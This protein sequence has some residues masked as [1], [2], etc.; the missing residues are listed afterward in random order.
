M[1]LDL[2]HQLGLYVGT[3]EMELNAFWRRICREGYTAFDCGSNQGYH[4]LAIAKRTHAQVVA[5]EPNDVALGLLRRNLRWNE[6][7]APYVSI[8]E[9]LVGAPGDPRSGA[10]TLDEVAFGPTAG[11]VPDLVKIDIE[12]AEAEALA[13]ARQLLNSRRP[14]MLI[15]THSAELEQECLMILAEAGYSPVIKHQ[16]LIGRENRS[17]VHNRWIL[18]LG[19]DRPA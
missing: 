7:L 19:T 10:V 14:H 18:G 12:G 2:D 4:S 8:V 15:E 16:R 17:Q 13:G 6:G 1:E 11:C 3:Y 5:F 9:A